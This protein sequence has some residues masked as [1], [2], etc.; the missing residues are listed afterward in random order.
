MLIYTII[1]IPVCSSTT[2]RPN[3]AGRSPA[4]STSSICSAIPGLPHCMRPRWRDHQYQCR[5]LT[6]LSRLVQRQFG[7]KWL[8]ERQHRGVRADV[9]DWLS[10]ATR[11]YDLIMVDP[12]FSNSKGQADFDAAD[13]LS[14]LQLAMARLSD[15]GVLYFSTNHRKFVLDPAVE[16][17][18]QV[19]DVT[20][21]SIPEDFS[22]ISAFITAAPDPQLTTRRESAP[23]DESWGVEVSWGRSA[24]IGLAS[25][26]TPRLFEA[27]RLPRS[28]CRVGGLWSLSF[29]ITAHGENAID[30]LWDAHLVE[31]R[32][33]G[34]ALTPSIVTC[35]EVTS[36]QATRVSPL[37]TGTCGGVAPVSRCLIIMC[38]RSR[39]N[40]RRAWTRYPTPCHVQ[41]QTLDDNCRTCDVVEIPLNDVRQGIVHVMGPE[42]GAVLPGMTVVCGTPYINP[43]GCGCAGARH[44]YVGSRARDGHSVFDSAKNEELPGR[45]P[46]C[47]RRA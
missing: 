37:Q 23:N 5:Q 7:A 40:E 11:T 34:T 9:R 4:V 33:D 6:R 38:R 45:D 20:Q 25:C 10:E 46:W 22:E 42:Q 13:H 44:R 18:W 43:W 39:V 3:V 30:K 21:D 2:G 24:F 29:G 8:M 12:V 36:P 27:Q 35:H 17:T 32:E 16:Q 26:Y 41:L 14:L 19:Q 31:E 1:W 15:E 47:L 28:V